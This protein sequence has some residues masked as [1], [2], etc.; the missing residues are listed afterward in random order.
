MK[1]SSLLPGFLLLL[2]FGVCDQLVGAKRQEPAAAPVDPSTRLRGLWKLH[3]RDSLLK[4][5]G[6]NLDPVRE[7]FK[8][9]LLYCR[10]GIGFHLQILPGG[11]VG[12]V[13]KPTEYSWLKVFA[14]KQGVVGIRGVR[15]GL[16]LCM[17]EEGLAYGAEEFSDNCLLK[18]NLEENHYTTYSSL[19]HP[20]IYLA[21][22][23]KG[24]LRKGNRLT[25]RLYCRV[26]IGFHL[27]ILPG[28]FVGGVHKPTEY[29]W[30]KVFAMKQGVVGIRG[31]RSGLYLC[32][33]EEGLAYGA[34]EF[35]D[36]CLLKENLE[37]NHYTTYSSLSH[38]GIYLALS[39]KG[40][41]RKGNRVSRH[42]ACT[43][44]LPRRTL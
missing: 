2:V 12:G 11:F 3:M 6:S 44:F 33:N 36:N 38:P 16:Y 31:V 9:Q 19:S 32:M 29:S 41:L 43:H 42:H 7:S 21:L 20:G 13:H 8:Q 18:E 23:H 24:E 26:G 28:G 4:G 27:Q 25:R 35:S 5:R 15:S 30:L 17:N 34:E 14:M 10:V 22:S 1:V 40:E 37:E 39:H